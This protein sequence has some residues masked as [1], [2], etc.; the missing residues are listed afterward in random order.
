MSLSVQSLVHIYGQNKLNESAEKTSLI[1][2]VALIG[3]SSLAGHTLHSRAC[4]KES[5]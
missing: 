1:K 4:Q 3:G 2:G 5:H